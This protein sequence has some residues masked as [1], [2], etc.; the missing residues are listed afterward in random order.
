MTIRLSLPRSP[1]EPQPRPGAVAHATLLSRLV[2]ECFASRLFQR[3]ATLWGAEAEAEAS[4]RLGW[5]DPFERAEGIVAASL[6]IRAELSA[7]GIT[8]VVLCGMGGSSLGPEVIARASAVNLTLVD[9]THPDVVRR[10]LSN[11]L[12]H[13]VVVVSSKS[14]GTLE[15]RSHAALFRDALQRASLDPTQHMI[16]VTDPGSP[17]AALEHD[18][19]RVVLADP[20]VGGR[21]SALTAFG[22]VPTV[23]AGADLTK[24]L[25]DARA[26]SAELKLDSPQNPALRLASAIAAGL[27]ERY[28]LLLV[29]A[30]KQQWG[31]GDWIEQLV[32]ES[33][34]KDGV[35]V[36]PIAVEARAPELDQ[37]PQNSTLVRLGFSD[38]V[39]AAD[40]D[41]I[42]VDAPLGSQ[43]ML[44]EVTTA[45]LGALM[46]INPFDQPDVESAKLAAN[47]SL[48]G[49]SLSVSS[50][51]QT[52]S[53]HELIA[54]LKGEVADNGYVAIQAF[55]DRE[56]ELGSYARELRSDIAEALGVPV[57]LGWGPRYL[58]STGQLHKGGPPLGTFVQIVHTGSSSLALP[59]SETDI[60]S[61]M[62]AQAYGDQSV[63]QSRGRVVLHL[64]R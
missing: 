12:A 10:A 3:D 50:E 1:S 37:L 27:P 31:L 15:T 20:Q 59:E 54:R 23:L 41:E 24:L 40:A 39:D 14:G 17:L 13:T 44:W 48:A 26:A 55:V 25:A 33:T 30:A 9:S 2:D 36:L 21:F 61:L 11:D 51:G 46:S 57:A 52:Y 35:G 5:V 38:E 29:E 32:A 47:A 28:V 22:I 58:H 42:V 16:Y 64:D 34:G 60:A 6:D 49:G 62:R 45:A 43:I 53:G 8:N 18:G 19:Y 7:R 4:Q 56:S 63:L